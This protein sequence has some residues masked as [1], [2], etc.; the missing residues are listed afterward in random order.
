VT[1]AIPLLLTSLL[2]PA[3]AAPSSS[4]PAPVAAPAP[5]PV[6]TPATAPVAAPVAAPT[7]STG[8]LARADD[9]LM[10]AQYRG[11]LVLYDEF[12]KAYPDDPAIPRVRAARAVIER[13]L[14]VQTENERLRRELDVRQADLAARQAEIDRLRADLERLRRID[15]RQGP[16]PTR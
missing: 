5:V 10:S 2:A 14:I 6:A 1:R 8:L 9:R 7:P 13:L 15:L 11:A 3:C 4:A 12:L 16:A